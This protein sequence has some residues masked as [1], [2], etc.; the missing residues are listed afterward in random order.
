[1]IAITQVQDGPSDVIYRYYF[2]SDGVQG[3]LSNFTLIDPAW[4]T[5]GQNAK[6]YLPPGPYTSGILNI[7]Q[8]WYNLSGFNLILGYGGASPTYAIPLAP[9][10]DSYL[11]FRPMGGMADLTPASNTPSGKIICKTMGYASN[12]STGWMVMKVRKQRNYVG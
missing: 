4:L 8:I 6:P 12:G 11:D 5:T 3:E 2:E 1:M 7:Q 9:D 10:N